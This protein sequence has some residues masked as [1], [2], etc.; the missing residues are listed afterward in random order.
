[1]PANSKECTCFTRE[2]LL[3][4]LKNTRMDCSTSYSSSSISIRHI[5]STSLPNQS[6]PRTLQFEE[7]YANLK[8]LEASTSSVPTIDTVCDALLGLQRLYTCVNDLMSLPLTEQALSHEKHQKLVDKLLDQSTMLLDVC[9][10]F[11]DAVEQL[12]QHV[13]DLQSAQRRKKG[14]MSL[15][16]SFFK[17]MKKDTKRTLSALKQV[18]NNIGGTTLLNQDHQL[19]VVIGSL[20]D[21]SLV[22]ISVYGSLLSITSVLVSKPKPLIRWSIASN[23]FHKGTEESVHRPQ[24]SSEALESHIEVIENGLACIFRSLIKTRLSLLN[25]HSY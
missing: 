17:K 14:D 18:T 24:V 10:S 6:H 4:L 2:P 7:E 1:M 8:T 13:R 11:R 5:R 23:L 15:N 9:G 19:S 12:K 16:T 25:S 21:T 20:R 3:S 22:S